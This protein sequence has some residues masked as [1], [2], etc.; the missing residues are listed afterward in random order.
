MLIAPSLLNPCSSLLFLVFGIFTQSVISSPAA[1]LTSSN[2]TGTFF[3]QGNV[4]WKRNN[5]SFKA[6]W[7]ACLGKGCSLIDLFSILGAAG[8]GNMDDLQTLSCC[9][10]MLFP[11][12]TSQQYAA[13]CTLMKVW[14]KTSLFVKESKKPQNMFPPPTAVQDLR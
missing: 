9:G 2:H 5:P 10:F 1:F 3:N 6:T 12:E 11:S 7:C 13:W 14:K 4:F 8:E